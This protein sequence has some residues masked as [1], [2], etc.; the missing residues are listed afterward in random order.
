MND[1]PVDFHTYTYSVRI[2]KEEAA[3]TREVQSRN[4][5]RNPVVRQV[6][7]SVNDFAPSNI[8]FKG[9]INGFSTLSGRITENN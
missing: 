8:I 1:V 2:K 3:R 6:F 4:G 9:G 5:A 7:V